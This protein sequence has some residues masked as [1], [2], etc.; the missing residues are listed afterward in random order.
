[1]SKITG[2]NKRLF[3]CLK[4]SSSITAFVS[5]RVK[6]LQTI[7]RSK[8]CKLVFAIFYIYKLKF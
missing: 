3:Q 6:K 1:M 4:I 2:A 8:E 7:F 5:P